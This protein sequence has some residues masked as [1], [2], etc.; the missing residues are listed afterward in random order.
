MTKKG[1][2]DQING[3][4][5]WKAEGQRELITDQVPNESSCPLREQ[6]KHWDRQKNQ[7]NIPKWEKR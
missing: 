5:W 6:L 2:N 4:E 3:G 7:A 1:E